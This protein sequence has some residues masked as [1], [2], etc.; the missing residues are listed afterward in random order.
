MRYLYINFA[1]YISKESK[2]I[3]S[4]EYQVKQ[5]SKETFPVYF[6]LTSVGLFFD[7]KY[8]GV[9]TLRNVVDFLSHHMTSLLSII[10]AM[11][12]S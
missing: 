2:T 10:N 5:K 12:T 7:P 8:T 3:S 6:L 11:R 1:V 4:V 9:K